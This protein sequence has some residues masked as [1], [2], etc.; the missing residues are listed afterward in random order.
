M[1]ERYAAIHDKT[2][3]EAFKRYRQRVTS[4]GEVVVYQPDSPMDEGMKLT[5]RLKR[6]RQTLP[7]GYCGRPLQTDCIHPN[8]C[9]GC[10]QY[11]TDVTFLPV[12]RGQRSRATTLEVTCAEEGR[13][14]WAERN[15]KDID[16]LTVIIEA[17]EDLPEAT[18]FAP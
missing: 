16:A 7:N 10:T 1:T 15:R 8:F 3:G 6:A 9:I 14:R 12:L 5:E 13:T 2:L 11:A 18:D 4:S 17:L